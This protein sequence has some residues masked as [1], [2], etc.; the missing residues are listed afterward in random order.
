M[1]FHDIFCFQ[2]RRSLFRLFKECPFQTLKE[3]RSLK[4]ATFCL[5]F[6]SFAIQIRPTTSKSPLQNQ[7]NKRLPP[8][9]SP[10]FSCFYYSSD[11]FFIGFLQQN[12]GAWCWCTYA[13]A[14]QSSSNQRSA[15][16]SCSRRHSWAIGAH[17]AAVGGEKMGNHDFPR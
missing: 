1:V 17:V 10:S 15:G 8:A 9:P 12:Q 11:M 5:L 14:L 13:K 7:A 16:C 6:E 4:H 3:E 2:K